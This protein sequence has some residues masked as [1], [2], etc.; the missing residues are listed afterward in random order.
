MGFQGGKTRR[1]PRAIDAAGI[2]A[3]CLLTASCAAASASAGAFGF[4]R[5][6]QEAQKRATQPYK[7]ARADLPQAWRD[8]DYDGYRA[9]TFRHDRALWRQEGLPFTMF[10]WGFCGPRA[11]AQNRWILFRPSPM[12]P[13]ATIPNA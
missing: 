1:R 13:S 8:L 10:T 7:P 4:D 3:W 12:R 2:L 11:S 9:I 6:R 5:L